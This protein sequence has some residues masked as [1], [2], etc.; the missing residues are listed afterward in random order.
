MSFFAKNLLNVM[1][2]NILGGEGVSYII[3]VNKQCSSATGLPWLERAGLSLIIAEGPTIGFC[4]DERG[5][6]SC[7]TLFES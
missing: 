5:A 1:L 7:Y 3:D 6:K 2:K 4:K